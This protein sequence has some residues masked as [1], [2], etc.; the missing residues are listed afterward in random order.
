MIFL[1]KIWEVVKMLFWKY[2]VVSNVKEKKKNWKIWKFNFLKWYIMK[3][4]CGV[5]NIGIKYRN[6][7]IY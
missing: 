3:E 2:N 1:G 7:E 5:F 6:K 4:E